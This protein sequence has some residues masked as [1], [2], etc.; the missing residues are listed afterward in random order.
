MRMGTLTSFV[1]HSPPGRQSLANGLCRYY[2][3]RRSATAD[4]IQFRI[5][6]ASTQNLFRAKLT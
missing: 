5:P 1:E 4:S 3:S 2:V 6:I